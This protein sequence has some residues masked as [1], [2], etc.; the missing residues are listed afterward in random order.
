MKP[1]L[2]L[3]LVRAGL[4]LARRLRKLACRL[5]DWAVRIGVERARQR[6]EQMLEWEGENGQSAT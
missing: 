1:R 3:F 5:E 4:R 2:R 6:L